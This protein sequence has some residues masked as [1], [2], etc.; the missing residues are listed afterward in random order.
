MKHDEKEYAKYIFSNDL[1]ILKEI[2]DF[3]SK[4]NDTHVLWNAID[5]DQLMALEN[6][7][8]YDSFKN[9][10]KFLK[11]RKKAYLDI[12]NGKYDNPSFETKRLYII[13]FDKNA[14]YA[15]EEYAEEDKSFD[16]C[17]LSPCSNYELLRSFV[18]AINEYQITLKD[19]ITII[20]CISVETFSN[21]WAVAYYI[22]PQ[23]RR[24]GYALEACKCIIENIKNHNIKEIV[25]TKYNDVYHKYSINHKKIICGTLKENYP[26][27]KLLEKL[28]FIKR[29]DSNDQI[30]YLL[31][32]E[33]SKK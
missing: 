22:I 9:I 14:F 23:Y 18:N 24:K 32:D 25:S 19:G 3:L 16:Y 5:T 20:G 13:T 21:Y 30:F 11:K 10:K 2:D 1:L 8:N 12:E 33:S 4:T 29:F 28:G 26:S 17:N 15:L 31:N 27:Q 6:F 7:S